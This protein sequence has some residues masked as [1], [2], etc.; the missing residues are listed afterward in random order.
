MSALKLIR[1]KDWRPALN[2]YLQSSND[3]FKKTGL[4]WG[5]FDCCTFAMDWVERMTGV[6]PMAD[7]RGKY[8][9]KAG[10][11]QALKDIGAG[12]LLSTA[13]ERLGKTVHP[14]HAHR[15]DICYRRAERCLGIIITRGT[16]TMGAFLHDKGIVGLTYRNLDH[17][18]RIG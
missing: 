3:R 11:L 12:T 7:F 18:F 2:N 4:V 5:K 1:R 8:S 9:T 17:A 13:R 16:L 14:S 6:D 10:A 15:G